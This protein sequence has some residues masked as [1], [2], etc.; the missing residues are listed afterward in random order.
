MSSSLTLA[1]LDA[2]PISLPVASISG[3]TSV[4]SGMS[5]DVIFTGTPHAEIGYRVNSGTEQK[6]VL[7]QNGNFI[8][9]TGMLSVNAQCDLVSAKMPDKCTNEIQR[10][11]I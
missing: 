3:S 1:L 8:L 7:D 6:V 10:T 9:P 2:L 4:C 5:T 11:V